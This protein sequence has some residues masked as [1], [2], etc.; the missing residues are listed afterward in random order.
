MDTIKTR[1]FFNNIEG[2]ESIGNIEKDNTQIWSNDN[3]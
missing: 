3:F 2:Y 1:N